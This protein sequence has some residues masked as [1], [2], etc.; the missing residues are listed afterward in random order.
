MIYY[1]MYF[2][3][4]IIIHFLPFKIIIKKINSNYHVNSKV[5]S[6]NFES[7]GS[8]FDSEDNFKV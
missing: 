7:F 8:V 5:F 3:I 6:L 1:E 4:L 2:K